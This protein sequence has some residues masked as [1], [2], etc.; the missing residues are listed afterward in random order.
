MHLKILSRFSGI[1]FK[2]ALVVVGVIIISFPLFSQSQSISLKGEWHVELES[3]DDFDTAKSPGFVKRSGS[4]ML[5]GSLAENAYGR[6]TEESDFGVLTPEYKFRGVAWYSKEIT[7]P[8]K[9]KNKSTTLFLERILWESR[10]FIDQQELS[11]QDGLGTPHIHKL[12]ILKPGKHQLK[13]RVD[14]TMIHNIGDKGHAYGAY[15]QSVWNGILGKMELRATEPTHLE[16][17]QILSNTLDEKLNIT[18]N[19]KSDKRQKV[20][21]GLNFSE[22]GEKPVW[23]ENLEKRLEPGE[24]RVEINLNVDGKLQ[25][26]SEFNPIVYKLNTTVQTKECNNQK[27]TE[28]GYRTVRHNGTKVLINDQPV[29]LRGNLDCVH[30]PLTGYVSTQVKDWERIFNIYKSYGLNHVRF[31]SWCPPEAAFIA[32]DRIGIYIQTEASIWID[33][34]MSEDMKKRGRPEMD[35]EGYPKGLGYDEKRDSFVVA[36]M[37]RVVESYGNHPSF[38]MFCI[39]NE[40]GNS[41]FDA[42]EKWVSDLKEKNPGRLYAVSTAR[43]ITE[44]DDY[45]ATHYIQG[46]GRTRGLNGAGTDWDFEDVYG[47]MNIPIIAH[48]IGQWP[49]YPGWDEIDKYTGVLKARNLKEFKAM[50]EKNGIADQDHDFKRASG[51]LNQLMY[52]YE[53]ESFLRTPSCAGIQLLSMQDYQGQGEALI[54]WLDAHWESKGITTPEKFRQHSNTT[55]PLLRIKKFVWSNHE[56]LDAKIQLSH[57]GVS[58]IPHGEIVCTIKDLNNNTVLNRNWLVSDLNV[59]ELRDIGTVSLPLQQIKKARQ[60]KISVYLKGTDYKNEWTVWVYPQKNNLP[61]HNIVL[62]NKLDEPTLEALKEGGKVLLNATNLGTVDNVVPINFYPLYWSLTFFP[63]QGKTSLGL[64]IN[65]THPVFDHFPTSF[66]SDWQWEAVGKKTKAFIINDLVDYKPIVQVVDDFHRNNKEGILMEF[67]VGKGKILVSGFDITDTSLVARQ[68]KYS[69]VKYMNSDRFNPQKTISINDLKTRFSFIPEAQLTNTV[70]DSG[71]TLLKV[72]AGVKTNADNIN[73][74]WS[75]AHDSIVIQKEG[76]KYLV[77]GTR[78]KPG[79]NTTAW[80]GE[81]LTVE[82]TC[83]DGIL[84]SFYVL[85][86][87]TKEEGILNFEGREVKFNAVNGKEG[88]WIKFHVMREDSNDG[89]LILKTKSGKGNK[90][91]IKEI[92]LNKE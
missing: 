35:T 62:A 69:L 47:K 24:N 23:T 9:W 21:I 43:K 13:V 55:V 81:K 56:V 19:I 42:M 78:N 2:K 89:K 30:F 66:H 11:V 65:E 15:T 26:W 85:L 5:P 50:A 32:A 71:N 84:G 52:K 77:E 22:A 33:W 53:M 63:G 76:I 36:E 74:D 28:F 82:I 80:L 67:G 72:I 61:E 68:L 1:M 46:I 75:L 91:A 34:W 40:L 16:K 51:A 83:P 25:K 70:D 3:C 92:L 12:G 38:I 41:N 39:G 54:G 45:S 87:T 8:K 7:I 37:H 29:F 14:N 58:S 86:G 10:V 60:L 44:I 73:Q 17:I 88:K 20:K 79:Q 4:I 48:E 59:G 27:E 18:L 57:H 64:L 6:K 31:H 49:V 90:I